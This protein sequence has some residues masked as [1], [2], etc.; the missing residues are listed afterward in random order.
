[1]NQFFHAH[2]L[3]QLL[4][5][6]VDYRSDDLVL[7]RAL[8]FLVTRKLRRVVLLVLVTIE[9]MSS[10]LLS[11]LSVR[12]HSI[13]Y[14]SCQECPFDCEYSHIVSFESPRAPQKMPQ[15]MPYE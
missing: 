15:K 9:V 10:E 13:D 6:S 5:Q 7:A 4:I 14:S 1:M 8:F 3:A 11:T 12:S 2:L